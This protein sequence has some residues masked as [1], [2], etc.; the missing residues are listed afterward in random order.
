MLE[1]CHKYSLYEITIEFKIGMLVAYHKFHI[2]I[3]FYH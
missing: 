2:K 3:L 1:G